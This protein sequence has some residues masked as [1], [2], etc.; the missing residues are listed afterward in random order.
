MEIK[1]NYVTLGCHFPICRAAYGHAN[2]F[3]LVSES[4][5]SVVHK[6]VIPVAAFMIWTGDL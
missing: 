4:S 3:P 2:Q 5:H 1:E 6:V